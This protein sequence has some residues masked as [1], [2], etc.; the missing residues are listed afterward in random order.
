MELKLALDLAIEFAKHRVCLM[1]EHV[2]LFLSP[3]CVCTV[4]VEKGQAG[5]LLR[6]MR[7]FCVVP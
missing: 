7:R 4:L 6:Q 3:L 1:T 2:L 5:A